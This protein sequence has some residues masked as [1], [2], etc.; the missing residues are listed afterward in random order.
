MTRTTRLRRTTLQ[1]LQIF[2][3]DACT[4]ISLL[5]GS[6]PSLLGTEH[7]TPARQVIR[8]QVNRYLVPRKDAYVMHAHLS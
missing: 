2:F 5:L 1:C 7:D 8:G 3:T 6:Y 4:F